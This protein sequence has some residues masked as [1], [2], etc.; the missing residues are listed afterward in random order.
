MFPRSPLLDRCRLPRPALRMETPQQLVESTLLSRTSIR[1]V[2]DW[3][4][5]SFRR[6]LA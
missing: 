6:L 3:H 2:I 4:S 5:S 1:P